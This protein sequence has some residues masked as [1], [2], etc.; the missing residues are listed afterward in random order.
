MATSGSWDY[1]VTA[2][3]IIQS[4][5]EDLGVLSPGATV[6][7]ANSTMALKR[8][9][10]LAKQW[11]GNSDMAPGMKV[12]TRQRIALFLAKGQQKYTVGPATTDSNATTSYGRTT[13]SAA[14]VANDTTISITSNTDSTNDPGTTVT[15]ASADHIG[16]VLDDGTL[17]WTVISGTPSTTA[18]ITTGLA[19]AAASGNYV[20]WYTSKAQRFPVLSSAALRNSSL[21]DSGLYV[22]RQVEDYDLGIAD[23]YADGQPSAVLVEPLRL[24]TRITF[25]SQPTDVTSQVILTALYPAEDYDATTDDIAF[26]QEWFAALSWE[27]AFR[28]SPAAGRWTK[29]MEMNRQNALALARSVNPEMSTMFFQPNA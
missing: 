15:M 16:I 3:D 20:Y 1:S 7:T 24:N 14:G 25:D 19:S 12:W 17:H 10:F 5:Y 29:E 21:N 11:Q 23:K 13:L 28:L 18:T 26:P 2:A 8:L 4:A 6:P 9:N 27:L 22:F